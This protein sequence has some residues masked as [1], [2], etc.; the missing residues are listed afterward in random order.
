[1]VKSNR[2]KYLTKEEFQQLLLAAQNKPYWYMMFYLAGNLGLRGG[3]LVRLRVEHIDQRNCSL[4]IP[5]LKQEG[6]KGIKRGSIRRGKMPS[7]FI[8]TPISQVMVDKI[9]E[10]V[11]VNQRKGWLFPA[12][13]GIHFPEWKWRRG[14]KFFAEKAKLNPKYSPH[15]LRHCKGILT[16]RKFK[17]IKAVQALLRHRSISSTEVYTHLD[18]DAKRELTTQL[19]DIE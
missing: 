16:Y 6:K 1:M 19:E 15:S 18:L 11:T 4:K 17:D 9:L 12:E 7:T 10:Y 14:F 8:D 2:D 13:D 5:T 3:E